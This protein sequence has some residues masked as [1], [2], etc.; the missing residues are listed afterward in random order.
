MDPL[1]VLKKHNL[2]ATIQ[3]I[4]IL[5]Y[6]MNTT[7]HPSVEEIYSTLK[8]IMPT[9][10]L[11]SIYNILSEF[12]KNNIVTK[13]MT[14]DNII[15]YDYKKDKHHHIYYED[16]K[17]EDLE[18]AELDNILNEYF[19]TKYPHLVNDNEIN[20]IINIKTI[21]PKNKRLWKQEESP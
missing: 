17:I 11:S 6:L 16:G 3:R 13:L 5:E 12:E 7:S 19:K 8:L 21:T 4:K 18:D 20:L 1:K 9:I 2:K 15:R 14:S 10:S